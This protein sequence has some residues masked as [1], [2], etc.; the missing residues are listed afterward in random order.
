MYVSH[1][2]QIFI[3]S[4]H[5]LF[6]ADRA[7]NKTGFSRLAML[8]PCEVVKNIKP[9]FAKFQGGGWYTFFVW[10]QTCVAES[11]VI[12][13]F[14]VTATEFFIWNFFRLQIIWQLMHI[15]NTIVITCR[16]WRLVTWRHFIDKILFFVYKTIV[17]EIIL[18]RN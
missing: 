6:R 4:P 7:V 12:Y 18:H 16:G 3:W 15:W 5:K 10:T 9:D 13:Y 17:A 8:K 1:L 2:L 11:W 14:G